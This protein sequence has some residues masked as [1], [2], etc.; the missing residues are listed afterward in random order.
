MIILSI[1]IGLPILGFLSY[2]FLGKIWRWAD[3]I[4]VIL[5]IATI[6]IVLTIGIV[7]LST[8][9]PPIFEQ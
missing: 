5:F 4:A 7:G 1:V 6:I 3:Y 8:I 2:H 9:I